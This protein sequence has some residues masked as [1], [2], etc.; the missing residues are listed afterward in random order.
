MITD[1]NIQSGMW[2]TH[3]PN[4][5][6]KIGGNVPAKYGVVS[7]LP[8]GA[9][10]LIYI[11]GPAY[12]DFEAYIVRPVLPNTGSLAIT[13][14]LATDANAPKVAQAIETDTILTAN[15]WTY[16]LS[17]QINYEEEGMIQVADV[18]GKWVDTGVKIGLLDPATVTR[19][20]VLYGFDEAKHT[21]SVRHVMAGPTIHEIPEALQNIPAVQKGWA[22]GAIMQ[23]Q[24]DT[25]ARGGEFSVSVDGCSYVWH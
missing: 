11:E 25:N 20:S 17:A 10:A 8:S 24:L 19:F 13:F 3:L 21:S 6:S 9:G 22:D 4:D 23:V 7:P 1:S 15:G 5:G 12:S 18:T 16:N 14:S 2:G